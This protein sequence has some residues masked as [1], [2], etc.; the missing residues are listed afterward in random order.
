M[1]KQEIYNRGFNLMAVSLLV[2]PGLAF[3]SVILNEHD[4]NDKIDDTV[5]LVSGIIALVWYLMGRNRFS[6]SVVPVAL[7]LLSLAGQIVGVL[8]EKDDKEAIGDNIGGMIIFVGVL[9]LVLYQYFRPQKI[10]GESA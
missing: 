8:I 6:R 4:F 2:L 1:S 7:V 5:L 3:G 10:E 9:I